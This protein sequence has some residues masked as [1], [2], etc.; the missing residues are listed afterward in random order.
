MVHRDWGWVRLAI[1]AFVLALT[2]ACATPPPAEEEE[3]MAAYEEANDP[4]EPFNRTML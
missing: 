1:G 3:A 4:L 2:A